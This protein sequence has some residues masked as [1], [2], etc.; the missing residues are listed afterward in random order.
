VNARDHGRA[1]RAGEHP[2]HPIRPQ[3]IVPVSSRQLNTIAT[4]W[5]RARSAWSGR[6]AMG[7]VAAEG[8]ASAIAATTMNVAA[9]DMDSGRFMVPSV[10][11][12]IKSV[13]PIQ[14]DT[15]PRRSAAARRGFGQAKRPVKELAALTSPRGTPPGGYLAADAGIVMPK[16][17]NDNCWRVGKLPLTLA[18]MTKSGDGK[19]P[20]GLRRSHQLGGVGHRQRA[21]RADAEI[22]GRLAVDR[23]LAVGRR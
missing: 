1:V 9:A 16:S 19:L 14:L 18:G 6:N 20:R 7:I 4:T 8:T 2:V 12:V 21:L 11:F 3:D 10:S 15:V 22:G 13:C 5:K 23:A 17:G